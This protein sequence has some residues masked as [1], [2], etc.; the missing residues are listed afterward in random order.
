MYVKFNIEARS[1]SH[2]CRGKAVSIT[3]SERVSVALSMQHAMRM[4][5]VILSYVV[6]PTLQYFSTL[7]HERDEFR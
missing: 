4:R 7:S 2:F 5:R 6:C 3:Y 1:R